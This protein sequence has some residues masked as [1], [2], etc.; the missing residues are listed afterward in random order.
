M[1]EMES[2]HMYARVHICACRGYSEFE[3]GFGISV[4]LV[5]LGPFRSSGPALALDLHPSPSS[6]SLVCLLLYSILPK[7][8]FY[9]PSISFSFSFLSFCSLSLGSFTKISFSIL[10]G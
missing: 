7:V 9:L 2:G 6:P 3:R 4:E 10:P 8:L 1:Y 5:F